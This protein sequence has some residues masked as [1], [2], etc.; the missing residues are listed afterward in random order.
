MGGGGREHAL[1]WKLLQSPRLKELYV[2]PGNGGTAAVAHN[3]DI[4]PT[5][6]DALA[7]AAEQY[8][9]DL[10]VVGPEAPLAS[11][12]VDLFQSRGLTIF[13]PTRA[14]TP[15]ESSKVFAKELMRRHGIPQAGGTVFSSL[16]EAKQF[17]ERH[18][19]PL[20]IKAD[21]LAAGKGTVVAKSP[22]EALQAL[23]DMLE[24]RVFGAAGD[25]VIVEECLQ[26]REVSFLAFTDGKSV[27]PMAPA[28]DY[29][30]AYDG[31]Q[32]PNTGGMGSYC[33]PGFFDQQQ[34]EQAQRSILEPVVQA[35]NKEGKPFKGVL[36]AGLMLTTD[37]VKVLEF[38]ARFGDPETQVILPR[39]KTDLVEILWAVVHGTLDKIKI[40]W[41]DDACVGVVMASG[42]YPGTYKTGF[43]ITGLDRLNKDILVFHAGTKAVP[44][45]I[46]C[47]DGGRVITVAGC[48]KTIAEARAKIYA[49]IASIHFENCHY[50]RD[51]ATEAS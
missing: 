37:G 23:S 36:Y 38:N 20:V 17:V 31:N 24:K 22:H 3:L 47:T 45:G 19:F 34:I 1:V 15:I 16:S 29:K 35:M 30:R 33:P 12:I 8:K 46:P 13:G 51:I 27:I 5:D 26:G 39:L 42:G 49:N 9:I 48:G 6:M 44:E 50:R 2:A 14:A 21:G 32:G 7:R 28:C 25:K 41:S 18:P 40:E 10:T 4:P 43:P 11:G